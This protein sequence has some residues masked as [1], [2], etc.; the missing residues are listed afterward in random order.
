MTAT[1]CKFVKKSF[2]IWGK[3]EFQEK[4]KYMEAIFLHVLHKHLPTFP[5]HKK[6]E[7]H[8]VHLYFKKEK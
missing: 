1:F 6:G 5:I 3:K 2:L 4:Q 7:G 8:I